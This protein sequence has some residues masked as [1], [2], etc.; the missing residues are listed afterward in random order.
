MNNLQGDSSSGQIV[1]GLIFVTIIFVLMFVLELLG[2]SIISGQSRFQTLV[3]STVDSQQMLITIYQN[4]KIYPNAI[5]VLPSI[6][7]RSGIEFAYSFFIMVLPS[8]FD[9]TKSFKHVFHKGYSFPWPLMGPGVFMKADTNAMRVIMN[10]YKNPNT[11]VDIN[12]IPINKWVHVVLN[13][14]DKGM[15][16]HINGALANRISFKDTIP[17]QNYEDIYLFSP[18]NSTILGQGGTPTSLGGGDFVLSG[19]FSGY[20]SKLIYTR[21]ALSPIEIQNLMNSGPSAI[22][23]NTNLQLPPSTSDDWWTDQN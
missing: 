9:G 19:A 7:E 12:N 17:Y 23:Q 6:N 16:V 2:T 3:P 22:K 13:C 8:T 1:T 20:F 5:P 15:D 14:I 18:V 21:Y 10:T 11:Y 4:P